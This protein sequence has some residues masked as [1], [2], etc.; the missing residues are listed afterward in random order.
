MLSAVDYALTSCHFFLIRQL[1][2]NIFG[3][4]SLGPVILHVEDSVVSMYKTM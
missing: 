1:L 2:L 4:T 3:Y